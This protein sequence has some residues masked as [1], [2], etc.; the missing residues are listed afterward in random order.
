MPR[1]SILTDDL[2]HSYL[3][4]EREA[5]CIHHIFEGTGRRKMSEKNGF[6]IPLTNA[7]HNMSNYGIHFNKPLD[8][9]IKRECQEK[10]ES[11]GHTREDFIKLVGRNYL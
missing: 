5:E 11:M 2:E 10:Y 1:F 9:K 4:P 7:E 8:L 3:N 6:I